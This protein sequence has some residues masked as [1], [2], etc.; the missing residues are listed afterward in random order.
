MEVGGLLRA[1]GPLFKVR[2]R[3]Q[4]VVLRGIP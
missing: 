3:G 4:E 2:G 1:R